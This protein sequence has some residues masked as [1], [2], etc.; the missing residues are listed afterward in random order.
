M[1]T[2][3]IP[4]WKSL[5]IFL[6]LPVLVL[7]NFSIVPA[8][9]EITLSSLEVD[10]WPEYDRPDLLVIYHATLPPQVSL[11]VELT[12]RIP[13]A[14]GEP[15]AVAVKQV[16]GA[17]YSVNYTRQVSGKWGLITF[18]ATTP[19]VQLEY[20]DPRLSKQ[21]EQ[22]HFE[23]QWSGDYAVDS[24]IVEVQQP[25]GA[26]ELH[27]TP[28][29]GITRQGAD[30]LTYVTV[31]V[32]AVAKDATFNIQV[33]YR[34]SSEALSVE[35]LQIQPSAPLSQ[36]TPG[37]VNL[38]QIVPWLLGA[39]G[40]LLL[41]GGGW[42]YWHSRQEKGSTHP[43]RRRG[44]A[45]QKIETSPQEGVYCHQCGKRALPG[46]RFCRWCGTRLRD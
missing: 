29:L 23:Y 21:G 7:L 11:P 36:Q 44:S 9:D 18:T 10:L 38:S 30:G 28:S 13:L 19:Q 32:G 12:F 46:D 3:S 33:D 27:L 22:R 4:P 1:P 17:L 45:P 25:V 31:E 8:Q 40:V 24:L 5:V 37:R 39:L 16:D 20:Y 35:N 15:H 34:K 42:W 41:A 26:S 43:H 14:A 6:L 2:R